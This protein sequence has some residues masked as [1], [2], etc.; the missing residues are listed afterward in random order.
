MKRETAFK[1][2]LTAI[3]AALASVLMY[4]EISV[5]LMPSFIKLEVSDFPALV[6][7]FIAGPACGVLVCLI[8]CAVH[9]PASYSGGIGELVNFVIGASFVLTAY[10]V[11]KALQGRRGVIIGGI[12]GAFVMAAVALPMNY[13]VTYPVY[14]K[15]MPM[16]AILQAYR[17]LLPGTGGLW[18]ALLIFNTP[19]NLIKGL[20]LTLISALTYAALKPLYER[21]GLDK[22]HNERKNSSCK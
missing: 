6:T 13:Y 19:F 7:S 2:A 17:E 4:L 20:L 3:M 12:C 11:Y 1:I 10:Y 18:S 16:E 14:A 21:F 9:L 8:K 5:P 15:M 22:K